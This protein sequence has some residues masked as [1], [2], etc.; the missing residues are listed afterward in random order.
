MF[1]GDLVA[2]R[3]RLRVDLPAEVA[4]TTIVPALPYFMAA[5]PELECGDESLIARP[6]GKLRMA[7][8]AVPTI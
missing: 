1:A 8:A 7:N 5:H 4:R 3:G 2:L 6:L